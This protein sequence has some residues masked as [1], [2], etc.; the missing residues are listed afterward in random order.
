MQIKQKFVSVCNHYIMNNTKSGHIFLEYWEITIL[1]NKEVVHIINFQVFLTH[2][3][4]VVSLSSYSLTVI[5]KHQS[6]FKWALYFF[7]KCNH[8]LWIQKRQKLMKAFYE[9]I[10]SY[11]EFTIKN[12]EY[13]IIYKLCVTHS[14]Y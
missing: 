12:I 2:I 1:V 7:I 10:S 9:G 8:K 6:T 5:E 14:L 4:I 11:R 13:F 3:L